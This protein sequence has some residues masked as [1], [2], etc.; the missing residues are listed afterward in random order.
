MLR[1]Q[2]TELGL[3]PYQ[4]T[5]DLQE[6]LR[7]D[8][9]AGTG[10]PHLLLTEHSPVLSLGRAEKGANLKASLETLHQNGFEVVETNRGGKVTY[11]GPGQLVAYPVVD[12]RALGHGVKSFVE[13]LEETMLQTIAAFGLRGERKVGCPGA[14]IQGRKIGSI[15]IHVRKQV[16]I[17]GLSLNVCPDMSHFGWITPCGLG[18]V[19]MTSMKAEGIRATV[20]DVAPVLAQAFE[21][22]FGVEVFLERKAVGHV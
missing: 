12:L 17:H 21:Q 3:Q 1:V 19:Q 9:L 10:G 14:W 16:S 18:D 5:W 15:G 11:H 22:V 4:K 20:A 7:A 13:G 6:S 2:L 8:L